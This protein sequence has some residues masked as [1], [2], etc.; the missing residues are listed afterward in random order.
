MKTEKIVVNI[1]TN[2]I[3]VAV[4]SCIACIS[5]YG[6][7]SNVFATFTDKSQL[8]YKGNE[9]AKCVTIMINVYWGTE[10]LDQMLEILGEHGVK[11]T[12]FVGGDWVSKNSEHLK[13]LVAEGHEIGNHG[14]FHKNH[15][16]LSY[17]QNVDEIVACQTVIE[18]VC[19]V[20]TYL[21]APPSGAFNKN[22]LKAAAD[23]GYKTIMWSKD[24][25]DWR[26]KNTDLIL[27]RATKNLS[28]GDLVLM[29]PTKNTVDALPKIIK[30][31]IEAGFNIVKVG[32]SI[33]GESD[34]NAI[35]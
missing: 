26:D 21:F 12:F 14:Y 1:L 29:H 23:L 20:K 25:I 5:F 32:E 15:D 13:K 19:G 16:K 28:N 27:S 11:A 7:V 2:F 24:T 34:S 6:G 22:T 8:F 4:V 35:L 18:G 9:S 3:L 31:Y 33:A 17:Q 30:F 10:Y